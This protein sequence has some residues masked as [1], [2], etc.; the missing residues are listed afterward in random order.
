MKRSNR[1]MLVLGV[2]LALVA[3]GGVLIFG[4]GSGNAQPAPT[5]VSVV[6]AAADIPLGTALDATML[7]LADK[8]IAEATDTYTD[9]APLLGKVVRQTVNA[10]VALT[11]ADFAGATGVNAA[12]VSS[13]LKPGQVAQAVQIDGLLGVGGFLQE[14]DYVDVVLATQVKIVLDAGTATGGA[15]TGGGS[16]TPF[17]PVGDVA[18]NTSVKVLVQNVQVIGH[19]QAA[20]TTSADGSAAVDPA[21]GQ[22][23]ANSQILILSVTPQQAEIIRFGQTQPDATLQ[24]VLRATADTT[25]ADATTTGITLRELID[26]YGVLPPQTVTV[27]YP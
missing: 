8:P 4:S 3:F 19:G 21:T 7:V 18:D 15:A 16:T 27:K 13:A 14:G 11:S 24:L 25:A 5:T 12:Q 1:L 2:V 26:K 22:A 10:G 23:L 20:A 17:T 6:T 9:P